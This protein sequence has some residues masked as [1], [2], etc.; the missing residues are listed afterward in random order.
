MLHVARDDK[1]M[2]QLAEAL[3]FFAGDIEVLTLP[4]WDCLPYDRVSPI[5]EV[6]SRRVETLTTL[7]DG[8]EPSAGNGRIVL[9][10]AAAAIQR[11]PTVDVMR[12]G[13]LAFKAGSEYDR[14]DLTAYFERMGYNLSLI[15][16]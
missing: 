4:A 14:A 5:S 6:T 13:K 7:A 9:T 1:R 16:I 8:K 15:H 12:K 11:V 10:T 3:Q 2:A